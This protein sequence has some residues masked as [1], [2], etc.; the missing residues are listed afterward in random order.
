MP[1]KMADCLVFGLAEPEFSLES[2]SENRRA[3]LAER[4][5]LSKDRNEWTADGKNY[6]KGLFKMLHTDGSHLGL[7]DE[8]HSTFRLRLALITGR[9]FCAA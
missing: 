1:P 5:F 4:G 3:I 9:V 6:V 7:S 2:I 8:Y